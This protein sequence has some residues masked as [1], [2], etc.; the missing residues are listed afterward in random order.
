M[1]APK[2]NATSTRWLARPAFAEAVQR[3]HEGEGQGI[4]NYMEDLGRR[5]PLK[6]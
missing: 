3:F 6:G 5:S 1:Q 2:I 4:E